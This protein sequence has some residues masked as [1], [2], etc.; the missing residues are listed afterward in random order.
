MSPCLHWVGLKRVFSTALQII[1]ATMK[2]PISTRKMTPV[3]A[4]VRN[5]VS[6]DRNCM[7][8]LVCYGDHLTHR[9]EMAAQLSNIAQFCDD[10]SFV[11]AGRGSAQSAGDRRC[12]VDCL[13]P[14]L[15]DCISSTKNL[16]LDANVTRPRDRA[17]RP[18]LGS[19]ESD[20]NRRKTLRLRSSNAKAAKVS[21][22]GSHRC[23][24]FAWRCSKPACRGCRAQIWRYVGCQCVGTTIPDT[25]GFDIRDDADQAS[26]AVPSMK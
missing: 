12:G 9:S 4:T 10:L 24:G 6:A 23:V 3:T 22:D 7:A 13:P 2:I 25:M 15:C 18:S 21:L 26:A 5:T 8:R 20:L 1:P 17:V 19:G 16:G 14:S 11:I